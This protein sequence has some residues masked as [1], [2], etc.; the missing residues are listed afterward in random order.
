[1]ETF[2]KV[3]RQQDIIIFQSGYTTQDLGGLHNL[4]HEMIAEALP[5]AKI[6]MMPQTVYFKNP[7]N[8]EHTGNILN[9]TKNML[10]LARDF[11]SFET[12][13]QMMPNVRVEAFPDIVTT[14][15]GTLHFNNKREGVCP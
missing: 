2:K 13:K 3:Y 7:E 11:V 1:L 8:Q 4:M 6:L 10:F 15:I 14:L 12:A 9:R 5:E